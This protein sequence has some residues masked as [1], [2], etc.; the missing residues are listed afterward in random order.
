VSATVHH[1]LKCLC[2]VQVSLGLE[3]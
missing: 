1:S 3:H 2:C